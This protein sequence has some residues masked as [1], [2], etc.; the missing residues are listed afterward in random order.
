MYVN[1]YVYHRICLDFKYDPQIPGTHGHN[2]KLTAKT[3]AKPKSSRQSQKAHGKTKK[4]MA[5]QTTHGKNK[6][7]TAKTARQGFGE[8][9]VRDRYCENRVSTGLD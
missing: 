1:I 2:K 6:K 5:N 7:L 9:K 3:E 8:S 4:L